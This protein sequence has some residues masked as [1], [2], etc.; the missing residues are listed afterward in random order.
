VDQGVRQA[1]VDRATTVNVSRGAVMANLAIARRVPVVTA[2]SAMVSAS[3]GAV[4][5]SLAN[6]PR[7][8]VVTALS[9]MVSVSPGLVMG[10]PVTG[11]LVPLVVVNANRG[12]AT[13]SRV[14]AQQGRVG[15]VRSVMVSVSRGVETVSLANAPRVP[16]GIDR[17][18]TVSVSPGHAMANPATAPNATG[19]A[20]RGTKM[21]PELAGR[22]T[23]DRR[24]IPAP[25][26]PAATVRNAI[27]TR[28]H[29]LRG[30]SSAAKRGLSSQN[31]NRNSREQT[32]IALLFAISQLSTKTTRLLSGSTWNPRHSLRNQTHLAR[33]STPS[34]RSDELHGSRLCAKRSE[35][36]RM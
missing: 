11:R 27:T 29:S 34:R 14:T 6:A 33:C 9:A 4:M 36:W 20:S 18:V 21:V 16:V 5:A 30:S 19:S 8:P 28:I 31:S 24:V 15:I 23:P 1:L 3:R 2:L 32:W 7:V 17:S 35:S 26:A 12:L 22:E 25:V 13:A 10:N